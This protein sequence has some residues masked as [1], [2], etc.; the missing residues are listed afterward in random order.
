MCY[1]AV[2]WRI[3]KPREWSS[4]ICYCRGVPRDTRHPLDSRLTGWN[5][6]TKPN[7]APRWDRLSTASIPTLCTV[8]GPEAKR[9]TTLQQTQ[10]LVTVTGTSFY[11]VPSSCR[12]CKLIFPY[13]AADT[14]VCYINYG[15]G[16]LKTG[17][18]AFSINCTGVEFEADYDYCATLVYI[19]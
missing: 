11:C 1:I 9:M 2:F 12:F 3:F 4:I 10:T 8:L 19:H 7:E 15:C 17:D 18:L 13:A 6:Q 5:F 16:I 14:A